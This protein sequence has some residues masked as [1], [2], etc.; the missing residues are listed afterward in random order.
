MIRA[1]RPVALDDLHQAI[2][3][4]FKA[5]EVLF[6]LPELFAQRYVDRAIECDREYE[7][8]HY[9]NGIKI[10]DK[11]G[12]YDSERETVRVV[13]GWEVADEALLYEFNVSI[14]ILTPDWRQVSQ[15]GDRDSHLHNK[16][17]E[18][19]RRRDD[20]SGPAAGGLPRRRDR[21]QPV[22]EQ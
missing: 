18:M 6:D 12:E 10:V 11:F 15:Y 7:P 14:Q 13:T 9:E 8:I 17:F 2:Q 16:S 3:A 19:V 21:L 5:C 4:D 1:I 20:N 22:P